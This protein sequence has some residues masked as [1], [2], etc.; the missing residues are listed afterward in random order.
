MARCALVVRYCPIPA[1]P[2]P[3]RR[4]GRGLPKLSS[5]DY[6][7]G[8]V[9]QAIERKAVI[10]LTRGKRRWLRAVPELSRYEGFCELRNPQA[11]TISRNNCVRF[12]DIR[13]AIEAGV[14]DTPLAR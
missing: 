2:Y 8:L 13:S 9:R 6:S 7:F 11:G 4:Y 1:A 12:Q 5:Q 3:S 14:A 10:V